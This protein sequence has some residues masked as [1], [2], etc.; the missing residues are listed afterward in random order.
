M[1]LA[2]LLGLYFPNSLKID[3][4]AT[5][6]GSE[7][8]ASLTLRH[9]ILSALLVKPPQGLEGMSPQ[10]PGNLRLQAKPCAA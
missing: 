9:G 8:L 10:Q 4:R 5:L 3:Q 7:E 2:N 1:N 6:S